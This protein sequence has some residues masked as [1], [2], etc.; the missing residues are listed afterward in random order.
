M[1]ITMGFGNAAGELTVWA[2]V[3]RKHPDGTISF[4]C[5]NGGWNGRWNPVD[6]TIIV[7]GY[8]DAPR[9]AKLL[10]EGQV[11]IEHARDYNS[12]I[13]WIQTQIGATQPC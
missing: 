6:Q 1:K 7:K 4:G 10:W 9:P 12:A 5:I 11:P 8:A 3:I 2:D 13:P